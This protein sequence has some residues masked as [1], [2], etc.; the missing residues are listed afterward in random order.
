MPNKIAIL[1]DRSILEI[2]GPERKK[3]LQGL[4]TNDIEKASE[5]HLI[6]SAMLAPQGRFLYDFFIFE[7]AEVI[8]ID[9]LSARRDELL[10]K[11]NFYKLRSKV[12]ITKND[13]MAVA[14]ALEATANFKIENSHS[15]IDPRNQALGH[16]LY[17]QK[18]SNNLSST[19]ESEYHFLRIKNKIAESEYDLTYDKSFILEFDFDH[20]NAIDYQKGC[21]VGQ[22]LTARTHYRGQIRKKLFHIK[23]AN[24][25]AIE[26]NSEI[27]CEGNSIGIVLSSALHN[28]ELHALALIKLAEDLNLED[29][30]KTFS[31]K[32]EFEKNRITIIT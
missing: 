30:I 27:T 2:K 3:F 4:I 8:I 31:E 21:Y 16:R 20:L 6:Y 26:K 12:E 25:P 22:E 5:S 24:L 13:E 29:Q 19:A 14:A 15:F 7:I 18:S 1:E 10:K 9:C 28:N 32:L 23:I 17:F 11:L